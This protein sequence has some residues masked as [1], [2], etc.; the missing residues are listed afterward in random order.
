MVQQRQ[1]KNGLTFSEA[2]ID[3]FT[4]KLIV[5]AVAPIKINGEFV[6]STCVDVSLDVLNEQIKKSKYRGE[7]DGVIFER[8]GNLLATTTSR[9]AKTAKEIPGI[10]EH[11]DEMLRNGAGYFALPEDEHFGDRVFAYTTIECTGWILGIAV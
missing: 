9:G 8:S 5:S 11:F 10:A 3:G 6:G 4:N 2:Y 7:G 1:R